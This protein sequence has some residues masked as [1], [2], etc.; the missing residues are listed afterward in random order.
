[1]PRYA[2]L[3]CEV[4]AEVKRRGLGSSGSGNGIDLA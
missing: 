3:E 1:M 4:V 2:V